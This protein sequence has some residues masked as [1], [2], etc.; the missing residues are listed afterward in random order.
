MKTV[1]LSVWL[2]FVASVVPAPAAP[3]A[4]SN[5]GKI[6]APASAAH[7][8]PAREGIGPFPAGAR[9]SASYSLAAETFDA[10]GAAA[11]AS[12]GGTYTVKDASLGTMGAL[13]MS[14]PVAGSAYTAKGGYAG[15][16]YEV[17]GLAVT[18]PTASVDERA[19][20][21]LGAV[22]VLD[23]GTLLAALSASAVNWAV[24]SGPIESVSSSGLLT[25]GTVYQ[26]TPATVHVTGGGLSGT[27]LL[28]VV[29]VNNDDYG[30]YAGDGLDDA[31][32]ARYFGLDNPLAAPNVDADGTGQ[33]NGFKY[34]AGLNPLDPKS[35]FVLMVAA[36]PG[37]PTQKTLTFSPVYGGRTYTVQATKSLTQPNWTTLAGVPV[38]ISGTTGTV[39][40]PGANVAARFYRVQ[41][42][43][44]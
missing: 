10:G 39:T 12:A 31:W 22:P 37:Q 33:T 9:A 6:A 11:L 20:L 40:D 36:A 38:T 30:S 8:I 35:R 4:R 34:L 32:Q 42:S 1:A 3:A 44:P 7:A 41:I 18:C 23:D 26:S 5:K 14:S 28:T 27:G 21:Q 17:R 2:A 24:G 25:A 43:L 15:Q 16:L 13:A 19:T 29:N